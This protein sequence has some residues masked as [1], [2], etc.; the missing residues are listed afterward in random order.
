M[1]KLP[2]SRSPG[3]SI[4]ET[5][6]AMGVI[7]ILAAILLPA[8]S[9]ARE[10]ASRATCAN[11]LKQLGLA[12]SAYAAQW[13]RMPSCTGNTSFRPDK[14]ILLIRAYSSHAQML[15][16]LDQANLF[17][18]L[19]FEVGLDEFM[20]SPNGAP[21]PVGQEANL[22]VV[23]AVV[24]TFLCPSDG[25]S[26]NRGNSYRCNQGT[27]RSGAGLNGPFSDYVF[28]IPIAAVTDGLS[29]TA[30]F[31]EK[32]R[33]S[34]KMPADPRRDMYYGPIGLPNFPVQAY[35]ECAASLNRQSASAT[36]GGVT[37]LV[38][39]LSQT[40]YNHVMIPNDVVPDC[41]GAG[42]HPLAGLVGARSNH[43]GG[44]QTAFCDGSVRF[45][46]NSI[47][48]STWMALGTRNGG[49]AVSSAEY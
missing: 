44:V 48:R 16:H 45:I 42:Y 46:T 14:S 4:V 5:L 29:N 3:Y 24:S 22:T 27:K 21:P 25:A 1:T 18:A 34:G 35:E 13:N 8:V 39:T 11:N 30:A 6:V 7:G 12:L 23:G 33:G 19:N 49:E 43:P 9:R 26:G 36:S 15:P 41:V 28:S 47:H 40:C 17:A 37:W 31:G 2:F 10:A 38:G 20:L 32:L